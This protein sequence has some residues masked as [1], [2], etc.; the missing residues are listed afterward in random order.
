MA[1]DR[2]QAN[3][4][5][6]V[7]IIGA[8]ISGIGTA[9]ELNRRESGKTFTI[10]EARDAIGGTWDLFRYPGIRSD[11]DV[12]TF[13][14]GFKAWEGDT[15]IAPGGE[16]REYVREAAREFDVE[17]KIRFRHKVVG[18][19]WDSG[20]KRWT[21][22]CE[23]TS[24][25]GEVSTEEVHAT[26][27]FNASGYYR[28]DKANNPELPGRED[29]EGDIIHPQYWPEG[30]D[31][32]GKKIVVL[33]SGATAV[34]LV[35]SLADDAESVTMLQRTP[36]Y[37]FPLPRV[38]PLVGPL[39]K[40]L[41]VD[42]AHHVAR[43]IHIEFQAVQYALLRKF[44]KLGRRFIET[45]AKR[46]LPKG[47]PMDPNFTPPYNPWDQRLC[48]VPDGDLFTTIA[49]GKAEIVTDTISRMTADGIITQSGKHLPC[50]LL[51]TATGFILQPLGGIA[52]S[53]DGEPVSVGK[54]A[55]YKGIMLSDVPNLAFAV[56]YTNSSWTLK[57]GLLANHF[58]RLLAYMDEHGYEV[59]TPRF[60][61]DFSKT[62]PLLDFGAG[63]VKR[64]EDKLPRVLDS[65]TWT[66]GNRYVDDRKVLLKGEIA[67]PDLEFA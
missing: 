49:E 43:A 54:H 12:Q 32:S 55:A 14:Y 15:M 9:I 19:N 21:I 31:Y 58:T 27:L 67:D 66:I 64:N 59:A 5:V 39:R 26:W 53:V 50:D 20:R 16:I 36:T 30:Y 40:L 60:S 37:M 11:S 28:Y 34:T 44:P 61:G 63:Y 17:D 41:G 35:P 4:E 22:T 18:A 7:V 1:E 42:R 6:D 13:S 24:T 3:D 25:N 62:R 38:S 8:G 2:T 51:I 47:Y 52:I 48:V 33:G 46:Y 10:L 57:I 45:F 65:G 29:F 56:G 23:V